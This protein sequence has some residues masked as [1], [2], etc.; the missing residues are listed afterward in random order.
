MPLGSLDPREVRMTPPAAV[1]ACWWW[2]ELVVGHPLFFLVTH[3]TD[4]ENTQKAPHTAAIAASSM[5][6]HALR[7]I[8][9]VPFDQLWRARA[10]GTRPKTLTGGRVCALYTHAPPFRRPLL[11]IIPLL[12][13]IFFVPFYFLW[14]RAYTT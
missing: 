9:C 7:R 14:V 1:P 13:V 3:T 5:C 4:T 2:H 10:P 8:G 11:T 12:D 6:R